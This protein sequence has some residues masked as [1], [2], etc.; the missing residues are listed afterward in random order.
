[1][2]NA[3][4][5]PASAEGGTLRV[6]FKV[7]CGAFGALQNAPLD[8]LLR[9]CPRLFSPPTV[10]TVSQ[11]GTAANL[12]FRAQR[13][14]SHFQLQTKKRFLGFASKSQ[15]RRSLVAGRIKDGA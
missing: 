11:H 12:S 13:G 6:R 10:E 1:M 14:I 9:A 8:M 4:F 7:Q 15:L 2:A 5:K 3:E